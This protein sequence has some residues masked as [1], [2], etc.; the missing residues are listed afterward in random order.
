M[1]D[2]MEK[3]FK[4]EDQRISME[5]LKKH[6]YVGLADPSESKKKTEDVTTSDKEM[7]ERENQPSK[8]IT[9]SPSNSNE[10]MLTIQ[11]ELIPSVHTKKAIDISQKLRSAVGEHSM[12][13]LVTTIEQSID[14]IK[15]LAVQGVKASENPRGEGVSDENN[16]D[17]QCV[18][19]LKK[20]L[21]VVTKA[22]ENIN[23][24]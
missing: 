21:H 7:S 14:E 2:V 17:D 5:E 12:R 24:T 6:K 20:L 23:T 16:K 22:L 10:R 1:T 8:E 15:K 13:A 3:I 4:P 11:K 9:K 18:D 19:E